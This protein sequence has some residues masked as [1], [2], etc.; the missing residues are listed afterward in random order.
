MYKFYLKINNVS[1]ST[2]ECVQDHCFIHLFL[3]EC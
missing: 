1:I 3:L 2:I